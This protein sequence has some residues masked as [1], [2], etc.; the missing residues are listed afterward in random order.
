MLLRQ[1]RDREEWPA[2]YDDLWARMKRKHGETAGTREMV[3]VLFLL[4]KHPAEDVHAAVH[5]A[6]GLGCCDAGA[7]AVLVRQLRVPEVERVP[8]SDDLG[9][10]G[11]VGT[12][13]T[14]DLACYDD[15]L[16]GRGV[17]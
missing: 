15:L 3:D 9:E 4:R 1:A 13:S 12:P 2:A 11:R 5:M 8:L 7:I 10:L 16:H 17:A 14:A 6:L